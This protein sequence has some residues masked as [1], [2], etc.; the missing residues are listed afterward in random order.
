MFKSYAIVIDPSHQGTGALGLPFEVQNDAENKEFPSFGHDILWS[1]ENHGDMHQWVILNKAQ[2]QHN[3]LCIASY[4]NLSDRDIE[5]LEYEVAL[6]LVPPAYK[7][8]FYGPTPSDQWSRLR[9]ETLEFCSA[10]RD[11]ISQGKA[12]F[13]CADIIYPEM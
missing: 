7:T 3:P 6:D 5:K 8:V 12:I 1:W 11:A 9:G 13:Y 4:V 10:A 2:P